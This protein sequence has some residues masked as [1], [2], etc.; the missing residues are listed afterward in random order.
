MDKAYYI[1][2]VESFVCNTVVYI[3]GVPIFREVKGLPNDVAI[4]INEWIRPGTNSISVQMQSRDGEPFGRESRIAVSVKSSE[5]GERANAV[6]TFSTSSPDFTTQETPK[7]NFSNHGVFTSHLNFNEPSWMQ[8][9][10]IELTNEL[11]VHRL[12]HVMEEI[13][14]MFKKEDAQ[15]LAEV[16]NFRNEEFA[17]AHYIPVAQR[18]V[19]LISNLEETWANSEYQLLSYDLKHLVPRIYGDGRLFTMEDKEGY[20]G[21]MYMDFKT[22]KFTTYPVFLSVQEKEIFVSR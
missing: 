15:G 12:V 17:I 13:W 5:K 16:F 8:S 14:G 6:E 21:I 7:M 1:L 3:N 2:E 10:V 9:R 22:P 18:T 4:P 11:L 20:P 19:D